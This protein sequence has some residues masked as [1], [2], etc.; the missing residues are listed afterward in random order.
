LPYILNP[1]FLL[2]LSAE[3]CYL[4]SYENWLFYDFPGEIL[5][6]FESHLDPLKLHNDALVADLHSDTVLRMTEG[7][8]FGLRD[9]RGSMDIP[10]LQEGGIDLQVFACWI[11]TRTPKDKCRSRA[12][13]MID[14]LKSQ[15]SRYRDK[16]AICKSASEAHEIISSG[17]IAA[18]IGIEN[19][20]AIADD[21][22]NLDHFYGRGVR[23]LTLTHTA[24]SDWCISS[25]DT[26]PKFDGLTDFGR[27]VVRKMND[28]GMIV[29][30][31]HASARAVEEVLK[32]AKAPIIASHSCVYALY[33]HDRNLTD[34]QIKAIAQNGGVIGIN[35]FGGYLSPRWDQVA[36]PI[37]E[38]HKEETETI[39]APYR[40]DLVK[41]RELFSWL[42]AEMDE[43]IAGTDIN[44]GTVVDHIDYLFRLV[45][46]D[47]IGLGS[48]FDG[49][50]SLPNDLK[51]CSMMPNITRE[52]VKRG[53][54]SI[55]I[56]KILGGNFM[57]VFEA[58]CH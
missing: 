30:V 16:I 18:L 45:G 28:L 20:V 26:E 55:D 29:D 8:D 48:D 47:Y 24:S 44:A 14:S 38:A 5:T 39:G 56:E 25:G 4:A 32:V 11:P 3:Q 33:P 50:F 12:D 9:S 53:Y 37:M 1:I 58:V 35:F 43:A 22:A 52:L 2:A 19:G 41:Q 36:G 21:L 6:D 46:P 54:S 49:V 10:R 31:S 51:D 27:D 13:L 7:F 15:V 40:D 57:R 42:F 34:K 17:R 23:C